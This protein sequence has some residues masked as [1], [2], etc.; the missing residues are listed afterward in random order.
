MDWTDVEKRMGDIVYDLEGVLRPEEIAET[1]EL[2]RA[3]E[4][5]IAL[6]NLC[7]QVS[8]HGISISRRSALA[9]AELGNLMGLDP[10][11][12]EDLSIDTGQ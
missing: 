10:G 7:T 5:G 11:N 4:C 9:V 8:E 3:G 1:R 12:W 6:E 2:V